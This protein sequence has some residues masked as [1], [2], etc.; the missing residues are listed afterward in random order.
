MQTD[1]P[2]SILKSIFSKDVILLMVIGLALLAFS[3]CRRDD[4]FPAASLN[5]KV[6]KDEA[7]KLAQAYALTTG[8]HVPRT[9]VSSTYFNSDSQA[10]TFLEYEYPLSEANELMR[11][12][13]QFG[14]GKYIS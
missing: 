8:F 5:L 4:A 10:S 14:V 7:V 6:S 2:G 3:F 13:I 11:K 1:R 9:I 12:E